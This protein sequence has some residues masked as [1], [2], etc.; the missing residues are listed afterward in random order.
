MKKSLLLIG[1]VLL[2]MTAATLAY[3][4]NCGCY[5]ETRAEGIAL[6][7]RGLHQKAVE[8]FIAAKNCNDVPANNDLDALIA[9]CRE[10][11]FGFKI[12]KLEL[13]NTDVDD[14]ELG[15]YGESYHQSELCYLTP[16]I[17]YTA[18]QEG[19]LLIGIKVFEPDGTL[20][21]DPE[22]EFSYTYDLAVQEGRGRWKILGGWG[23]AAGGAFEPGEYTVEI[24]ALGQC[25]ASGKT[26]VLPDPQPEPKV[27]V[28]GSSEIH[29]EFPVAG[30]TKHI[31][32]QNFTATDFDAWLLPDFCTVTNITKKG[33]DLV[34]ERNETPVVRTDYF[35]VSVEDYTASAT[36]YVEQETYAKCTKL[37]VDGKDG[38]QEINSKFEYAGGKEIFFVET[39]SPDYQ[40]WGVPGFCS[41]HQKTATSFYIVCES[42]PY[43]EER[44]D[45]FRVEAGKLKVTVNVSQA[46]NPDGESM[47]GDTGGD[48]D[49]SDYVDTYMGY[50]NIIGEPETWLEVLG[51]MIEN[52]V[53]TYNDGS[54]YKGL[55]DNGLRN[56]YGV[57]YWPVKSYYFGEWKDGE[58]EGMGIYIIG[59]FSYKFNNCPGTVVY[60]GEFVNNKAHG[61]GTCYDRDGNLVY[62][63]EFID[64]V[65]QGE[66]PN[67]EN[68]SSYKFQIFHVDDSDVPRWY[69][70]ETDGTD[71]HGW[72]VQI[73]DD[74]DCCFGLWSNGERVGENGQL[75]MDRSGAV[76]EMREYN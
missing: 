24:W 31:D 29:L 69:V 44:T 20:S 43:I 49:Q 13:G 45:Y 71:R 70:G 67:G 61:T 42:N 54:C 59:D 74:F 55:M 52:P 68:Y 14:R 57:Y 22:N 63:G 64:G 35:C 30:G 47:F 28:N 19:S 53:S 7:E 38:E 39:D 46:G 72:G 15:E 8:F 26:T 27:L 41:V 62:Y 21:G 5:A 6:C 16:R 23:T 17:T 25:L 36:V 10:H 56:G 18:S 65:P 34:C 12:T 1:A 4:D 2:G 60:V 76:I 40:I 75:F 58:R 66:Y 33:F 32:V 37:L 3:A 9:K 51:H 48:V 11:M 73:W 50:P